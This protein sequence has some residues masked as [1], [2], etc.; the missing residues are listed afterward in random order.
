MRTGVW[1]Y[2]AAPA[3]RLIDAIRILDDGD[4]DEVWVADEGVARDPFAVLAVAAVRTEHSRLGVGITSP[5]LRHPGAA[6][7]AAMTIDELAGGGRF[8]LGWGVGGHESLGPFGLTVDKPVRLLAEALRTARAVFDGA[9][10]DRYH[11]PAHAAPTYCGPQLNALASRE[12]DGVFLSGFPDRDDSDA[13]LTDVVTIAR[14]VRPIDVALYSSIRFRTPADHWSTAGSADELAEHLT[15]LARRHRP[16]CIGA[17][18][19]D[20]DDPVTMAEDAVRT[21][22]LVR[23]RLPPSLD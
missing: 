20:G 17:A 8:V 1:L 14:S 5:L 12:A 16:T 3:E 22:R 13:S 19:V 2:P 7:S 18:L 21:F 4:I 11:P 9:E 10:G 23:N 6:A 15:R